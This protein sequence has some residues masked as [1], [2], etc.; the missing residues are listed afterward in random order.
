MSRVRSSSA[1]VV[2]ILPHHF[3]NTNLLYNVVFSRS[4]KFLD[5]SL[6]ALK[7]LTL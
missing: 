3:E 4:E 6:S 1:A 7:S 2:V 5:F